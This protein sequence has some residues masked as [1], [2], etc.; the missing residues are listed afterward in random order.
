MKIEIKMFQSS[1]QGYPAIRCQDVKLVTAFFFSFKGLKGE[2]KQECNQARDEE[3][4]EGLHIL[5]S[6]M[7]D[8]FSHS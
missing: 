5:V 4:A 7:A 6:F 1:A 3:K 2:L 8:I